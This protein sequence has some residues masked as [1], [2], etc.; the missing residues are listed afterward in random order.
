M[1]RRAAAALVLAI[2]IAPRL[3]FAQANRVPRVAV[4]LSGT[5]ASDAVKVDAF[6]RGLLELGYVPGQTIALTYTYANGNLQGLPSMAAELAES[7]VDVAVAEGST[8]AAAIRRADAALP[9]VLAFSSDPIAARLVDSLAHPG[10]NTTGLS[11][12]ATDLA[13]KQL[14]ILKSIVPQLTTVA[15]LGDAR[16]PTYQARMQEVDRAAVALNLRIHR[17]LLHDIDDLRRAFAIVEGA[18]PGAL[19]ALQTPIIVAL[20]RQIADLAI[21][22]RLPTMYIDS[23]FAAAG[24]LVSYGPNYAELF[25]RS[26]HY[27]DKILRGVRPRDIP[28]EQVERFELVINLKTARQIG[29]Q[30]PSKTLLQADRVIE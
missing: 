20:H 23:E 15:V 13:A 11:V 9:I 5:A 3:T 10:G 4:V 16:G 2:G 14:E 12:Q 18:R 19:L 22:A 17:V 25:K 24:G 1:D 7:K 26:A 27:V 6:Q 21:K 30:I 8:V 29:L 28:V